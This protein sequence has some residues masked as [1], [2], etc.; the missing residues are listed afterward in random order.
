MKM[1]T[2]EVDNHKLMYHPKRVTE[3]LE[4]GDCAPVYIEVGVTNRCNHKCIFC[5]LDWIAHGGKDIEKNALNSA[6]EGMVKSGVKSVMF[7][8][9]GEPLLHKNISEF[10]ENAKNYGLDVS[11]TTNGTRLTHEKANLI[12]PFL[13]W[14]RF[15]IDAGSKESYAKV[16]G[17]KEEDFERDRKS[18]V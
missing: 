10:V 18:V 12:L 6:L 14:I 3:W 9:E 2:K 11:I 13:S 4:K 16:H 17:T 15:S 1:N 5:A 8:G 7:A